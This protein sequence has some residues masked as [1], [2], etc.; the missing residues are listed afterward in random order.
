[1]RLFL[2]RTSGNSQRLPHRKERD[3]SSQKR[4]GNENGKPSQIRKKMVVAVQIIRKPTH[5]KKDES[6]SKEKGGTKIDKGQLRGFVHNQ[7]SR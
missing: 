1:M 5:V 2:V 3:Q 4:R 6:P 7:L